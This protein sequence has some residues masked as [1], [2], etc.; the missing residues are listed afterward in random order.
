M[1][2]ATRPFTHPNKDQNFGEPKVVPAEGMAQIA[3]PNGTLIPLPGRLTRPGA[4]VSVRHNGGKSYEVMIRYAGGL[5]HDAKSVLRAVGVGTGVG[6]AKSLVGQM[7]GGL[8]LKQTL[9]F[10]GGRV[11]NV[12]AGTIWP[13]ETGHPI[14]LNADL[15]TGEEVRYW[16]AGLEQA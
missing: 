12:I 10:L 14:E 9:G 1:A 2:L 8:F 3:A 6:T 4:K 16:I 15:N 7:G 11:A 5:S 13:I